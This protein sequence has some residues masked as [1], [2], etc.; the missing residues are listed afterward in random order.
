MFSPEVLRYNQQNQIDYTVWLRFKIFFFILFFLQVLKNYLMFHAWILFAN[1]M[2]A[3]T[4]P[5]L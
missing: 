4:N 5:Q 2:Q 1:A 3:T